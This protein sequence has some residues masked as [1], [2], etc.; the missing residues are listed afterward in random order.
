M[1]NKKT[2]P[3]SKD[4]ETGDDFWDQLG[5]KK[6]NAASSS[7]EEETRKFVD[8]IG[9]S[10]EEREEQKLLDKFFRRKK[11][12]P[13]S[14]DLPENAFVDFEDYE[15]YK[16]NM[17]QYSNLDIANKIESYDVKNPESKKTDS[18]DLAAHWKVHLNV[19]PKNVDPVSEYLIKNGF[20]HKYLSGGEIED[21]KVFTVYIGSYK[22]VKQ[23]SEQIGQDLS[24][25]L[26]KPLAYGEIELAP[27]VV[28][29]FDA[30]GNKDSQTNFTQYGTCG[31]SWLVCE[32]RKKINWKDFS[33]SERRKGELNSFKRLQEIYGDY[34]FAE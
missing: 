6:E 27:G 4:K 8:L 16:E 3:D 15:T 2:G 12:A 31:F 7:L 22:L 1:V 19:E 13:L 28:G 11:K 20:K 21:G 23:L 10:V 29:R 33:E 32:K 18:L 5:N 34:F 24:S 17:Q 26:C 30:P 25:F 14:Q 9:K